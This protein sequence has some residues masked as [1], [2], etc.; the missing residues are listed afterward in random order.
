MTEEGSAPVPLTASLADEGEA[1][2][3]AEGSCHV[4]ALALH[5][6][7]GWPMLVVTNPEEASWEDPE[8]SDNRIDNVVHVFA[9]NDG[10]AYDI[11]GTRPQDQATEW[12]HAKWYDVTVTDTD[13][14]RSEGELAMYVEGASG[15]Y[16][17]DIDP[18]RPLHSYTDADID[19]AWEVAK[20]V[21]GFE[22]DHGTRCR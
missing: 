14:C 22:S 18:Y 16:D 4:F 10:L 21:I 8:D 1:Q 3:Y 13:L 19:E 11:F 20:R 17:E 7:L 12:C 9:V 5:R 15:E 6:N 2:L